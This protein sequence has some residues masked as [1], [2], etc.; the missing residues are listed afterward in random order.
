VIARCPRCASELDLTLTV[1]AAPFSCASCGA[2][3]DLPQSRL[4]GERP[5]AEFASRYERPA[6]TATPCTSLCYAALQGLPR[7][8]VKP[9]L[10][11]SRG[12]FKTAI[13]WTLLSSI[14][15]LIGLGIYLLK[16][17]LYPPNL[18]FPLFLG[19]MGLLFTLIG[20]SSLTN[21]VTG[22]KNLDKLDRR[23]LVTDAVLYDKW[24]DSDSDGD[25]AYTVAFAFEIPT[26]RGPS[27]ITRAEVNA[28][29]YRALDLGDH[30]RVKYLPHDPDS[31]LLLDYR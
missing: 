13:I 1:R 15:I 8:K 20:V 18:V 5:Q 9:A 11:S 17:D 2:E 19:G 23:G 12:Q 16:A 31:S 28:K 29:A 21:A 26:P 27:R 24:M 22:L 7:P 14:F 25:S 30:T 10:G 6:F 3:I 4:Q